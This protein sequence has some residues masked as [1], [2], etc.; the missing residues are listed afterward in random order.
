MNQSLL[1]LRHSLRVLKNNLIYQYFNFRINKTQN[2]YQPLFKK[3]S[4]KVILILGHMRSGSSLL[5]NILTSHAAITGYGESHIQYQSEADLK[6]L[7][8]KVY[9]HRQKFN[10][11]PDLIKLKMNHTYILDKLLHDH[12]L[13]N[14]NILK[15]ENF[16]LIFL[17]REPKTSLK[18][19]LDHKPHWTEKEALQYY[20]QRLSTLSNYAQIV[21]S[22][23]HSLFLTYD[24]LVN[25]TDLVFS[26]LQNFLQTQ[27]GFS[28]NYQVTNTTGMRHVGD[29]KEYIRSGKIMRKSR[30]I[31]ISI[32]SNILEEGIEHFNNC[33]SQLSRFCQTIDEKGLIP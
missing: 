33:C 21:N 24:E 1:S 11:L 13:L 12:K 3:D 18:S 32:S 2:N 31:D 14:E 5:T 22:K 26:A 6:Q 30:A 7:M 27:E 19:M 17:I 28:E 23:N 15:L 20:S 29:F 9:F 16:Y 4:Y 25:E 8:F 10:S